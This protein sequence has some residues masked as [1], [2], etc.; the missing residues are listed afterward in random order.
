[1]IELHG[2][3]TP[4]PQKVV[5]LLE[6]LGVPYRIVGY[7]LLAGA[8][9]TPEFARINPNFKVPAIVDHAPAVGGEPIAVFESCAILQYLADKEG[10]FL[11]SD[12]R[13]RS[14]VTQ[15][16]FWQAAGLGPMLGQAG[17]F[18]RY[19]PEQI[20]YA[21]KRYTNEGTR[22][23]RV[24]E[25]RLQDNE[26]LAGDYSIADIA[27]WPWITAGAGDLSDFPA[28]ARWKETLDERPA[29]ARVLHGDAAI[30]PEMLK[31]RMRLTPEQWSNAFGER[32]LEAPCQ[33]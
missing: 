18:L 16:L 33:Q 31:K 12:P 20:E 28:I 25:A 17:H 4:N 3:I 15:W 29:Y 9:F 1:M 21:I 7:D 26:F 10:R 22:L 19:A 6:E 2:N 11:P 13:G 30:P 24:M 14:A 32:L 23:L 5:I 8:H 27:C